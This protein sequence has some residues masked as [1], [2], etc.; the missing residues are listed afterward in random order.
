MSTDQSRIGTGTPVTSLSQQLA[1]QADRINHGLLESIVAQVPAY[2]DSANPDVLPRLERHVQDHGEAIARMFAD[3]RAGD[4]EFV[5]SHAERCAR[6]R[7]PL[8]SLLHSYRC[9][10]GYY[11]RLM[12]TTMQADDALAAELPLVLTSLTEA[13]LDYT[14]TVSQLATRHYLAQAQALETVA[15][16]ERT[17]L[18]RILLDGYDESDG[19]VAGILRRA[20][21]LDGRRAFCVAL[22]RSVDPAEMLN[23]SRAQ[24]MADYFSGL[25]EGMPG[26]QLVE[27]RNQHVTIIFSDSRRAS[28]WTAARASLAS[29]VVPV[30][31][32]VGPVAL[33]GISNDAPSTAGVP[34][35]YRE[36]QLALD[37]ASVSRRVV[38]FSEMSLQELMIRK[39][40]DELMRVLP[41]WTESF[42]AAN[43]KS[44]GVLV[45]TLKAY[46]R[47][48]M[49]VLNTA[50]ILG[51]HPNTVYARFDRITEMTGLMPRIFADLNE[52]LIVAECAGREQRSG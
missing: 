43:R 18:L 47:S 51:S 2:S 49:N 19:R 37:G 13:L 11:F 45:D 7:F 29:K 14:D 31:R 34:R 25:L 12:Q 8:E 30:L 10:N 26:Q 36:A 27:V 20:G 44:R 50:A 16:D 6:Q 41:D 21:Y 39:S 52:L 9:L 42:M 35:A 17:L 28:G 38:Q 33:I 32:K 5:A 3:G 48:S 22:A 23:P 4:L 46:A 24:R 40:A 15:G 1:R